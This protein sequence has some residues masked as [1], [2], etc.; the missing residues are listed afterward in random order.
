MIG[1]N[2]IGKNSDSYVG[3]VFG[4]FNVGAVIKL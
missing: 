3:N 1:L 4:S 2:K